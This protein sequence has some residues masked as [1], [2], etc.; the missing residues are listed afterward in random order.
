MTVRCI[1][2]PSAK[3]LQTL[4]E[5]GTPR[6]MCIV[7]GDDL[8][9]DSDL[10][11]YTQGE[12]VAEVLKLRYAIRQHRDSIGHNLCW[13]VPELWNTLPERVE[14]EPEVPA[15]EEFLSC[16]KVYRDSLDK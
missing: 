15:K 4:V 3:V 10:D 1:R 2:H 8:D 16:C 7:C 9:P 13:F 14:V 11:E 6:W 12:L 5:K